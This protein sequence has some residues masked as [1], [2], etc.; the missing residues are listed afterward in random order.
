MAARMQRD[1]AHE[2]V[3]NTVIGS[4]GQINTMTAIWHDRQSH[5]KRTSI[6]LKPSQLSQLPYVLVTM[7]SEWFIFPS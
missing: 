2:K 5:I 7:I 3:V 1:T 4:E 6:R